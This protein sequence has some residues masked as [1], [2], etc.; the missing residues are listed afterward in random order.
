M[1]GVIKN[2]VI[3]NGVIKNGVIKNGVI[4][5]LGSRS[6]NPKAVLYCCVYLTQIKT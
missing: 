3:N 2:G 4:S 1:N 5:F 6:Q